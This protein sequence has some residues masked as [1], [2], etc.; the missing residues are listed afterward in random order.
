[1]RGYHRRRGWLA[2]HVAAL[3]R[4][5]GTSFP[6]LAEMTGEDREVDEDAALNRELHALRVWQARLAHQAKRTGP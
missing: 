6:E 3:G 5:D 2:W 4:M 1:M